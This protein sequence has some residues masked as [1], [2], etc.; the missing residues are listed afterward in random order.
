MSGLLDADMQ[1][2]RS[3]LTAGWRWWIDELA[4]LVPGRWRETAVNRLA[5]VAWDP[6]LGT[7][8][9]LP[10]RSGA[11]PLADAAMALILPREATLIR[12]IETPAVSLRDV[13]NLVELDADRIMPLARNDVLLGLRVR[14]RTEAA[15]KTPGGARLSVEVAG[16]PRTTAEAL[17]Q[18]L[19]KSARKPACVLVAAPEPGHSL[20]I[21]L[22]PA[23]RRA[24]L[25]GRPA[26][27]S[28]AP[29][30]Y[31]AAFLF[32]LN[33]AL[34][35]WRDAASVDSLA[36]VVDAQAPAVKVAHG[37]IARMHRQDAIVAATTNAR[38]TTEPLAMLARID[39][40]LP[41][42]TWLQRYSWT[43][44]SLQIAGFHPPKTDVPGA[45]RHAG[46]IVGRYGNTSNEAPTPL[47]EP[48]EIT[49]KLGKR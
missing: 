15:D 1:T 5:L 47:G 13:A 31:G 12:V 32:A 49:L 8:K 9:P 3:W 29:W 28:A 46:L 2:I 34:L 16:L 6:A 37:I 7:L 48:F 23:L 42:G 33:I 36:A 27:R 35:V 40:A 43:G 19:A 25:A 39:A 44:D 30:W 38:R 4:G 22:L 17:S 18:T 14:T 24:G 41:P 20:P 10:A 11:A 21:D 45:L 26:D